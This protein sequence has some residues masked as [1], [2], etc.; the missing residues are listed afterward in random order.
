MA[1]LYE[2]YLLSTGLR[3]TKCCD[4]WI[5][6]QQ[7]SL[8][9]MQL[10]ISHVN[11]GYCVLA[12]VS[13]LFGIHAML[14]MTTIFNLQHTI[15]SMVEMIIKHAIVFVIKPVVHKILSGVR[16]M[17]TYSIKFN[18]VHLFAIKIQTLIKIYTHLQH[19]KWS[20]YLLYLLF[21]NVTFL[22]ISQYITIHFF[23][24]S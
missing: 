11:I 18:S 22:M 23:S 16:P 6:I 5:K 12:S 10:K 2:T 7:Y 9:K 8:N 14:S 1:S 21:F 19:A 13:Q 24:I 4:I 17:F 3:G 20:S 15:L